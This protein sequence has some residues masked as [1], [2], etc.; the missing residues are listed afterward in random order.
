MPNIAKQPYLQ[1]SKDDLIL[2]DYLAM[3]RTVLANERT[4]LAYV[5]TALAFLI[6][7]IGFLKFFDDWLM[8][9]LGGIFGV[10]SVIAISIGIIRYRSLSKIYRLKK[11]SGVSIS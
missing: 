2:R 6:T 7:G 9:I 1:T 11:K 4:F 5:R 10:S 3:D 8:E